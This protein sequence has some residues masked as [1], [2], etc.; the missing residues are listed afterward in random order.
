MFS[1]ILREQLGAESFADDQSN[2]IGDQQESDHLLHLGAMFIH[3]LLEV[4]QAFQIP[5]G[6]FDLHPLEVIGQSNHGFHVGHDPHGVGKTFLPNPDYVHLHLT[7]VEN[8][9]DDAGRT[10]RD[11]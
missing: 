10:N 1:A 9:F 5:E 7:F 6:F 11:T 8:L 3:E 4:E 2:G